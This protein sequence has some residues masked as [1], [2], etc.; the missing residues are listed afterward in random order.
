MR[1]RPIASNFG[2][3]TGQISHFV[4]SQLIDAQAVN[5]HEHVLKDSLS[6]IRLV[7]DVL[8]EATPISPVQNILLTSAD[9][10]ALYPSINIEDGM[11]AF[12]WF[13]AEHTSLQIKMQSKYLRLGWSSQI[14]S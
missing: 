4:H 9:V 2:Y 8:R 7:V 14:S 12:E 6:L 11:T 13:M 1:S 3:P 10:V 5:K